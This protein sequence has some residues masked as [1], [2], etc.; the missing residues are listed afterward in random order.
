MQSYYHIMNHIPYTVCY[1]PAAYLFY[2]WRFVTVN[3][4]HLFH[5]PLSTCLS[6]V[7]VCFY[8]VSF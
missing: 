6:F 4:L 8:F 3:P 2:D 1:I 7:P 5:I